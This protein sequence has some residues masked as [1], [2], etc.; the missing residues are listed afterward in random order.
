[1]KFGSKGNPGGSDPR[2]EDFGADRIG[3][4]DPSNGDRGVEGLPPP[5]PLTHPGLPFKNLRGGK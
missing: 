5:K 1:M 4:P 2:P 3:I